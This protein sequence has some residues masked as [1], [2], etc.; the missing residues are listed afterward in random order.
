V[1]HLHLRV[2]RVRSSKMRSK[3]A[4]VLGAVLLL[5]SPVG[6]QGNSTNT[7]DE[8]YGEV[9]REAADLESLENMDAVYDEF[10]LPLALVA[11]TPTLVFLLAGAFLGEWETKEY[12]LLV[13]LSGFSA[14]LMLIL[15]PGL[16]IHF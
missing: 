3:S 6:A 1:G 2:D 16:L 9:V 15:Y 5:F 7:T 4:V 12:W 8:G 10:G 11:L 14:V 13:V